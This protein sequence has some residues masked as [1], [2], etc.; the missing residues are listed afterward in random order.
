MLIGQLTNSGGLWWQ[1]HM[2][3]GV[4]F[5]VGIAG[6]FLSFIM[7]PPAIAIQETA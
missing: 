7:T 2:W 1:I 5:T 4:P 6:Y 3:L